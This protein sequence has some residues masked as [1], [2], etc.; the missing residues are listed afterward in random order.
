MVCDL[1]RFESLVD[2]AL[3]DVSDLDG[4]AGARQL[5]HHREDAVRR[6]YTSVHTHLYTNYIINVTKIS[7]C[8]ANIILKMYGNSTTLWN[9]NI[10]GKFL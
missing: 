9:V 2:A 3:D 7:Q 6:T 4:A 10:I 1:I 8:I 5:A